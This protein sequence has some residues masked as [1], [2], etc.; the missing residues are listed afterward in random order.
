MLLSGSKGVKTPCSHSF[1]N[2]SISLLVSSG[3]ISVLSLS[4]PRKFNPTPPC[5]ILCNEELL[6]LLRLGSDSWVKRSSKFGRGVKKIENYDPVR[7]LINYCSVQCFLG[8]ED[9][10]VQSRTAC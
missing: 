10:N 5:H 3:F 1:Y 7:R 9:S 2:S 4:L 6:A 8:V